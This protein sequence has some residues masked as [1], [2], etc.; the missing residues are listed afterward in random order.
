MS[1]LNY[2]DQTLNHIVEKLLTEFQ[3]SRIFLFG[4]RAKGTAVETSDYDLLL[5]IKESKYSR[6]ERMTKAKETL[7]GCGV[8]VDVFV[9][10]EQEFE[11]WKNE[12]SSIP[13]TATTE[14]LELKVG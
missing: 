11:D 12:F 4:S 14:G 3:P 5:I 7:W 10:T 2:P 1:L 13:H 9:Y 8:P 6:H